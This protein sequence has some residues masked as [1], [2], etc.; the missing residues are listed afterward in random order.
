[1]GF[2]VGKVA[3][4]TD[5]VLSVHYPPPS[6]DPSQAPPGSEAQARR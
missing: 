4:K 2:S 6:S 3:G 1:L 5:C